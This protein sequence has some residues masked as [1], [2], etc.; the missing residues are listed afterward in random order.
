MTLAAGVLGGGGA[1]AQSL[2]VSVIELTRLQDSIQIEGVID[3]GTGDVTAK[4][5]ILHEGTGGRM[6]TSQGRK[7]TLAEGTRVSVAMTQLNIGPDSTLIIDL[8]V[9]AEDGVVAHSQTR[10]S[11]ETN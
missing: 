7:V 2:P 1:F 3:G 6:N 11:P 9:E 4:L 8:V 10:L 5:V